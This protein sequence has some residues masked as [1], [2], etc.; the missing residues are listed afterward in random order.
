MLTQRYSYSI[1][2]SNN[3]SRELWQT[4][5][6]FGRAGLVAAEVLEKPLY[7]ELLNSNCK[8]VRKRRACLIGSCADAAQMFANDHVSRHSRGLL[9]SC[10]AERFE[11]GL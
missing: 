4:K 9:H 6:A 3:R 7:S 2:A 1:V 10:L 5:L 11:R 8:N